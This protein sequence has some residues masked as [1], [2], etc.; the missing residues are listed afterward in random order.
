MLVGEATHSCALWRGD[1]AR[2]DGARMG[3]EGSTSVT[4]AVCDTILY[5]VTNRH[6]RVRDRFALC[7][8][9]GASRSACDITVALASALGTQ[10]QYGQRVVVVAA[11]V[12]NAKML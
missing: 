7:G 9:T 1:F 12:A 10:R 2:I 11:A 8:R 6:L 3:G 4:L 5:S